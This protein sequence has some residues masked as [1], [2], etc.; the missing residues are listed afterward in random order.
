MEK[1]VERNNLVAVFKAV[2]QEQ[3]KIRGA[4]ETELDNLWEKVKMQK[5]KYFGGEAL[6][7]DTIEFV[8]KHIEA[9][10]FTSL[11]AIKDKPETY[12]K[13]KRIYTILANVNKAISKKNA[14]QY[15]LEDG[16]TNCELFGELYPDES[17]T[18]KQH[19]LSF[20]FPEYIREGSVY[21]T[22]KIEHAGENMHA[23]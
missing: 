21:M 18:R 20:V 7:W 1:D 13:H 14:S 8:Y 5:Q 4:R 15:E 6:T 9:G 11:E 22:L 17:I 16:A 2:E 23:Q 3:L 12:M 19:V 10:R